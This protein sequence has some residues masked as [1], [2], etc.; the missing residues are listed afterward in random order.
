MSSTISHSM[1][2]FAHHA[3]EFVVPFL[4]NAIAWLT[5]SACAFVLTHHAAKYLR[6][7]FDITDGGKVT[8]PIYIFPVTMITFSL[9]VYVIMPTPERGALIL[10]SVQQWLLV[11]TGY[12]VALAFGIV[13]YRLYRVFQPKQGGSG[14]LILP[15]TEKQEVPFGHTDE[16]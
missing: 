7:E 8:G 15:Q 13:L 1:C 14:N 3:M 6:S 10:P 5:G 12:S 11:M 9:I 2:A 4:S 16:K